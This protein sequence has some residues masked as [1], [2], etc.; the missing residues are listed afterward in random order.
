M[1]KAPVVKPG[2]QTTYGGRRELI[3]PSCPLTS[4]PTPFTDKCNFKRK[5]FLISWSQLPPLS[6]RLD[7]FPSPIG[8]STELFPGL[9]P[10]SPNFLQPL[11]P[12]PSPLPYVCP[13][14]LLSSSGL[15]AK[16]LKSQPFPVWLL[17]LTLNL[18]SSTS[19]SVSPVASNAAR[20]S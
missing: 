17:A 19:G 20:G 14:A 4:T 6:V 3:P 15:H 2:L 8:G 9:L 7:P 11:E 12:Q 18:R 5:F 16:A 13:L 10:F 1:V